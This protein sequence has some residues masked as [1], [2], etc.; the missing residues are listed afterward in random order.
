MLWLK[1]KRPR[2]QYDEKLAIN[3]TFEELTRVSANYTPPKK[4]AVK[5]PAK[6]AFKKKK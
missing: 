6:K 4:E 5:K 1:Q 3:G 2:G